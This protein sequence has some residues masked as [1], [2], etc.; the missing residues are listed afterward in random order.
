MQTREWPEL[1][2][3]D[4]AE[5]LAQ[6]D[7]DTFRGTGPG[8]QKRNKTESAVRLRHRQSG[9]VSRSDD[10]RSQHQNR[11]HALRRLRRLIALELRSRVALDGYRPPQ[12]LR[13]LLAGRL[14]RR[15]RLYP[16][17]VAALLD[18]LVAAELKLSVAAEAAGSSTSKLS[19]ALT[20]DPALLQKI[21]ALRAAADLRPLRA[22]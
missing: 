11:G 3:L 12:A 8:G 9:L 7:V 20:N 6:C 19:R 10:S 14:G 17:A 1:L 4:D 5:L 15:H 13:E 18:L 21:N 16:P 22:R 2:A